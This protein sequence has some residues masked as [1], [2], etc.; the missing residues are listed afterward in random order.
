MKI[1]SARQHGG[2]MQH[3]DIKVRLSLRGEPQKLLTYWHGSLHDQLPETANVTILR[4]DN[5]PPI[6][7]WWPDYFDP[8]LYFETMTRT[9]KKRAELSISDQSLSMNATEIE[10]ARQLTDVTYGWIS[11]RTSLPT[12]GSPIPH[13]RLMLLVE[14]LPSLVDAVER[15][16]DPEVVS[17][18]SVG[19]VYAQGNPRRPD[20]RWLPRLWDSSKTAALEELKVFEGLL[21]EGQATEVRKTVTRIGNVFRKALNLRKARLNK[22][23]TEVRGY[24]ESLE[25]DGVLIT[26]DMIEGSE[27]G[28]IMRWLDAEMSRKNPKVK[29]WHARG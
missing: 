14:G 13:A 16:G 21:A 5:K 12:F 28:R 10:T 22:R 19:A 4:K 27:Y 17:G 11:G 23:I 7:P 18:A 24:S 29:V 8:N 6:N 25:I 1:S 15:F 2:C 3:G 26:D 20:V 9:E